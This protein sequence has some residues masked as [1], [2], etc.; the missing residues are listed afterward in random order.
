[1]DTFTQA[2][3]EHRARLTARPGNRIWILDPTYS[4]HVNYSEHA[5]AGLFMA[6]EGGTPEAIAT[7]EMLDPGGTFISDPHAGVD[8]DE[9]EIYRLIRRH[10]PAVVEASSRPP[11][12]RW[13]DV[14]RWDGETTDRLT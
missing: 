12:G 13:T 5:S 4:E 7:A 11:F 2:Y 9:F 14:N 8:A 3:I 1:M 10:S 6:E